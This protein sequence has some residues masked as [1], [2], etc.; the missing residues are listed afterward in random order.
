MY[1][2]PKSK[3]KIILLKELET[4][5][6]IQFFFKFLKAPSYFHCS[7]AA[8]NVILWFEVMFTGSYSF[9]VSESGKQNASFR[10]KFLENLIKFTIK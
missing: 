10:I 7:I 4:C 5:E 2:W 8:L 6:F 9:S 3:K 1:L